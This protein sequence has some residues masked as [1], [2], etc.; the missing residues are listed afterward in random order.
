MRTTL[1]LPDPLFRE[2][3]AH[4]AHK[5]LKLKELVTSFIESGLHSESQGTSHPFKRSPLPVARYANGI[6]TPALTN[7]QLQD[8]MDREDASLKP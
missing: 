8:L 3:K 2:L 5:G 7:V 6:T 4:A 1:D